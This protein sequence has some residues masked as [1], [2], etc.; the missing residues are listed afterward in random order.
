MSFTCKGCPK[1]TPGCHDSC[2]K[3]QH[4]KAEY[5]AMKAKLQKEKAVRAGLD[6]Q[7][8]R[9]A[10]RSNYYKKYEENT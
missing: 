2:E 1:R 3:Y 9:V 10:A 5:E 4:E 6:A 7:R 8:R